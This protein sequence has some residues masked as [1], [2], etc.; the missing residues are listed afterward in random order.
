[1][2]E[3]MPTAETSTD[4][5]ELV[6]CNWFTSLYPQQTQDEVFGANPN[7]RVDGIF[8]PSSKTRRVDGGL[9]V[10]GK[11]FYSSGCLQAA[12]GLFGVPVVNEARVQVDQGLAL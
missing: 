10:T 1:M 12:W 3:Q 7:V 4:T 6:V 2:I 5:Q 9:V 8:A 11:L